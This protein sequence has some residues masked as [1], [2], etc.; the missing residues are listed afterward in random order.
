MIKRRWMIAALAAGGLAAG[1][2][3]SRWQREGL[4]FFSSGTSRDAP[5]DRLAGSDG[6]MVDD[7]YLPDFEFTDQHGKVHRF[8]DFRDRPRLVNFWATWCPPCVHEIPILISAQR[9]YREKGLQ[10]IGIAS[11]R[12]EDAFPMALRFDLNYPTM[13]DTG[14]SLDLLRAFKS[15]SAA[16]PFSVFIDAENV[17]RERHT[18]DLSQSQA[19]EKIEALFA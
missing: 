14:R 4:A 6:A 2:G 9:E 17:I 18:G 11:D 16:L 7:S 12:K 5:S 3:I 10:I 1:F 8:S 15:P 19:K 13:A